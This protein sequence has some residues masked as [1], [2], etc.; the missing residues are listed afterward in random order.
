MSSTLRRASV[1]STGRTLP[2]LRCRINCVHQSVARR[3][4]S[5]KPIGTTSEEKRRMA[6]MEELR[7]SL[8]TGLSKMSGCSESS[9]SNWPYAGHQ[10]RRSPVSA[11]CRRAIPSRR[12][13]TSC[14]TLRLS[15]ASLRLQ[16]WARRV[17]SPSTAGHAR[18]S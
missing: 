3:H 2:P 12:S 8:P 16:L 17:H 4:W 11:S 6:R 14:G 18:L 13:T 7:I 5:R 15:S 1:P 9:R 10:E